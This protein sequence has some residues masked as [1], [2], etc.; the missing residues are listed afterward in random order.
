MPIIYKK[1]TLEVNIWPYNIVILS[2][3]QANMNILY[4]TV[5]YV[6]IIYLT[7]YLCKPDYTVGELMKNVAK[8]GTGK[9]VM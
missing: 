2:L 8:E 6:M 4:A 1:N 7:S 5:M 3:L 9:E